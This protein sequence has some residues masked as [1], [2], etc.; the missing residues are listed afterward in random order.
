MFRIFP[1][2]LLP[3]AVYNLVV[4]FGDVI[5]GKDMYALLTAPLA[6]AMFSGSSGW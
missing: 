6:I 4:L 1:L 3:V 2:M 5:F